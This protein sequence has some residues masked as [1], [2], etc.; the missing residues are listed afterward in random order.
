MYFT[1]LALIYSDYSEVQIYLA[2][3]CADSDSIMRE[4]QIYKVMGFT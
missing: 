1:M 4:I 2:K 3:K